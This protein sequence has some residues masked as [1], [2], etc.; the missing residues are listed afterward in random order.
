M[1]GYAQLAQRMTNHPDLGILRRFGALNVQN[2]LYLQ[3][4]LTVLESKL[5]K[6]EEQNAASPDEQTQWC[7]YDWRSLIKHRAEDD[8]QSQWLVFLEVR[9]KL[10]EYSM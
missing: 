10:R 5:R 3:A 6:V 7:A 2:L 8:D 4:E 9:S 1:E